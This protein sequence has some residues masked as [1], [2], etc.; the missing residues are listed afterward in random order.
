M[1]AA[2]DQTFLE[3]IS[4]GD[5]KSIDK[6][7]GLP[8]V[9]PGRQQLRVVVARGRREVSGNFDRPAATWC[10]GEGADDGGGSRGRLRQVRL[11]SAARPGNSE[12]A[13]GRGDLAAVGRLQ[14][15]WQK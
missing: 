15:Q 14:G 13:L 4:P 5:S 12:A 10:D 1:K 2:P 8:E 6:I 3:T 7:D 9:I 11:L